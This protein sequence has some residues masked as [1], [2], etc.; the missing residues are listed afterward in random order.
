[1]KCVDYN[2]SFIWYGRCDY[3]WKTCLLLELTAVLLL[4]DRPSIVGQDNIQYIDSYDES[5]QPHGN[6]SRKTVSTLQS[7][8]LNNSRLLS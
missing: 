3:R 6:M 1:M 7:Q 5:V 2:E 4:I 8:S